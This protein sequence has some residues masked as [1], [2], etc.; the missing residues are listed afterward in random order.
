MKSRVA[1]LFL[2]A[3]AA[4]G[5]Q[6]TIQNPLGNVGVQDIRCPTGYGLPGYGPYD[7]L[8]TRI[9]PQQVSGQI[10]KA[11]YVLGIYI[12]GKAEYDERC[13]FRKM[14][15]R[16]E[17]MDKAG[18]IQKR[19]VA[20][21]QWNITEPWPVSLWRSPLPKPNYMVADGGEGCRWYQPR[22][23]TL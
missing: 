4:W 3:T 2:L 1:L 8:L 17:A 18:R 7:T 5:Q 12:P 21:C 6:D 19:W 14:L 9:T 16:E 15:A 20:R 11:E 23:V 22:E 13:H 10:D